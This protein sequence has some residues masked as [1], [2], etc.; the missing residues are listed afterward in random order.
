MRNIKNFEKFMLISS[1]KSSLRENLDEANIALTW[2]QG[3]PV[4]PQLVFYPFFERE[5]FAV[6]GNNEGE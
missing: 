2:L 1:S 4:D 5:H 6:A 3:I